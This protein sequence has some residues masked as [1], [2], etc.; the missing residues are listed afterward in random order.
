MTDDTMT[1]RTFLSRGATAG[2]ALG[3]GSY[4]SAQE[5]GEQIRCGC[6][7]VGGRGTG[8]LQQALQVPQVVFPAICDINQGNLNAA[9]ELVE[10]AQGQRPQ[11]YSADEYDYRN[12]LAR[13]DLDAVIIAT[14]CHW[15]A[16]M[17]LDTIAAGKHMYGE[18]PMCISVRECSDIVEAH[19]KVNGELVIQIGF[20][21]RANPRYTESIQLIRDGELGELIE[22][23]VTMDNAWGPL[24]DWRSKREFSGDWVVEQMV[25]TWDVLNWVTDGTPLRAFALGRNDLFTAEEPDRDVYDHYAAMIEYPSRFTVEAHHSWIAPHDSPLAGVYERIV[26]RQGACDLGAGRFYY[27]GQDREQ[28]EVGENV[29]DT[30]LSVQAFFSSIRH[31]E[32]PI[33]GVLNGRDAVLVALLVRM[34]YDNE[35][36]V[37]W[38]EML[39]TQ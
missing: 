8:L 10:Q 31:H 6:I 28:K 20:Q 34:A 29:D 35:R 11:G 30:A 12:L 36:I 1:R 37:T 5:G 21:R 15:H 2:L 13:D 16:P 22:G 4:L 17:Y 26:G 7:G 24:R 25:H 9:L 33:S 3:L 32:P 18:K 27:R 38:E 19:E 39:Q 14:P 23:R